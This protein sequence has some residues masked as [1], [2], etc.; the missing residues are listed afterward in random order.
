[1][2]AA[3]VDTNRGGGY[4]EEF[5]AEAYGLVGRW[6]ETGRAEDLGMALRRG[7]GVTV[8][9]EAFEQLVAALEVAGPAEEVGAVAAASL[10]GAGTGGR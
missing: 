1:M 10:S 7:A 8:G 2:A 3:G 4:C 5:L 9:E 6:E